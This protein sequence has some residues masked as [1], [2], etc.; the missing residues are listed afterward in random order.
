MYRQT[1][2]PRGSCL[3]SLAGAA[4]LGILLTSAGPAAA[5]L[6][7]RGTVPRLEGCNQ[8]SGYPDCHPDRPYMYQ[9]RSAAIPARRGPY[10]KLPEMPDYDNR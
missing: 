9:G 4:A 3:R 1:S 7:P 8:L 2:I 5:N 6:G 10:A